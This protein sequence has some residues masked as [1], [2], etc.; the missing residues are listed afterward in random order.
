[1][2]HQHQI[3]EKV[4]ALQAGAISLDVFEEWFDDASWGMHRNG[5][6]PDVVDLA[7]SIDAIFSTV[8]HAELS[9]ADARREIVAL[10][11]ASPRW[12]PWATSQDIKPDR[13]TLR[14]SA[15]V[16]LVPVAIS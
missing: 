16:R 6:D 9:G 5:S 1:M 14:S 13:S 11:R 8:R 7:E 3:R 4:A 10:V 15:T 12:V 2:L